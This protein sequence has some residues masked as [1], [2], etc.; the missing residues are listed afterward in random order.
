MQQNILELGSDKALRNRYFTKAS[1]AHPA[2]LHLGLLAWIVERYTQPGQTLLDPMAGVGSLSY[3]ALLQR[4][5]ILREL[6]TTWLAHAHENAANIIRSAGMFA[7]TIA[8]GQA[9]ARLPWDVQADHIIFSPPY[10]CRASSNQTSRHYVSHKVYKMAK[11]EGV[12]YTDRWHK[13][14]N[15]PTAGAAGSMTFFYGEHPAQVGHLRDVTYWHAM[16]DIYTQAR[17]CLRGGVMVLVIKD[18]IRQGERVCIA[19][20]TVTLCERLGF[21]LSERSARHVYPL[22]L[23]QRRRKE[24]GELIVEDEDV[25][26]FV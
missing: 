17:A 18:H 1:F 3:A 24:R 20:Q 21:R 5:V 2:K 12:S 8:I 11:D 10:A 25:L 13:F 6:E 7:G 26:V 14:A 16:T 19:D 9:D 4:N 15:Q 23:W 22:S